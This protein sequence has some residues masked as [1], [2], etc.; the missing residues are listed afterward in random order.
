VIRGT[1]AALATWMTATGGIV[2]VIH[3]A[4]VALPSSP[5]GNW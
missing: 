4:W 2:Y 3:P 1:L 5:L